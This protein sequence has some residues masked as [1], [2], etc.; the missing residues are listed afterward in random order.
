MLVWKGPI[1][2]LLGPGTTFPSNHR[3]NPMLLAHECIAKQISRIH[4]EWDWSSRDWSKP[5]RTFSLRSSQGMHSSLH[6]EPSRYMHDDL[7]RCFF[8]CGSSARLW[9]T[10]QCRQTTKLAHG[11]SYRLVQR[12][13]LLVYARHRSANSLIVTHSDSLRLSHVFEWVW[14]SPKCRIYFLSEFHFI[15]QT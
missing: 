10:V 9:L 3:M 6:R 13:L 14:V 15:L 4:Q 7:E 11:G 1:C 8:C 5:F 12:A 2:Y